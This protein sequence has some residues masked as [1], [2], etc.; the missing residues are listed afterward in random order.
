MREKKVKEMLEFIGKME[1]QVV[2]IRDLVS[3]VVFNM[4]SSII[5]SRDLVNLENES[6]HTGEMNRILRNIV[7]L[8]STP[9][10]MIFIWY[11]LHLIC[12]D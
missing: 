5:V 4:L 7:E 8:A 11:W 6:V 2:K 12:K 9:M 10:Y 1:G 3:A